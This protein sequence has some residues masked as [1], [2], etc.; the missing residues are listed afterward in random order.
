MS[1][2]WF[3]GWAIQYSFMRWFYHEQNGQ[4]HTFTVARTCTSNRY[5]ASHRAGL[6]CIISEHSNTH[7]I[8]FYDVSPLEFIWVRSWRC[9]CLVTWFCYQMIAKPGNKTATRSWPDPYTSTLV[10]VRFIDNMELLVEFQNI[11]LGW[12]IEASIY[13]SLV[14]VMDCDLFGTKPSPELVMYTCWLDRKYQTSMKCNVKSFFLWNAFA[15][16]NGKFWWV[17]F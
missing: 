12:P 15:N 5:G 2:V 7:R 6:M 3:Y 14:L 4:T 9:G 8:G 11:K 13:T 17:S 1:V 10:K 16:V